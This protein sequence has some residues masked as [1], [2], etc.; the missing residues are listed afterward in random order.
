MHSY[1]QKLKGMNVLSIGSNPEHGSTFR[2]H[3]LFFQHYLET[4][5]SEKWHQLKVRK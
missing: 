1:R 2:P 4:D 3:R 5:S